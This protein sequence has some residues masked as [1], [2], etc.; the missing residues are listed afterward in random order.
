MFRATV[1][2]TAIHKN[3][4]TFFAENEIRAPRNFRVPPPTSKP[5]FMKDPHE[6]KFSSLVA[7]AAHRRH[8]PGALLFVECVGHSANL[9]KQYAREERRTRKTGRIAPERF[10]QD[11]L[12]S[13][14]G[15]SRHSFRTFCTRLWLA[16][17]R[18]VSS[19]SFLR[20]RK[21]FGVASTY[22]SDPMYSSARSSDIFKGA[23]S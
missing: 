2:E 21:F 10:S 16:R 7:P 13:L 6:H 19:R 14:L 11:Q 15:R 20:K 5:R 8:N 3:G 18:C 22:S 9:P 12:P 1:P 4:D 17:L 23:S